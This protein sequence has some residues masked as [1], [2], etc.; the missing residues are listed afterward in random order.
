MLEDALDDVASGDAEVEAAEPELLVE[1]DLDV[2]LGVLRVSLEE[3][4]SKIPEVGG[5]ETGLCLFLVIVLRC[6]VVVLLS[7]MVWV[8][9]VLVR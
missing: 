7:V 2:I 5:A 8:I 4:L 6:L 3:I 1:E 9:I